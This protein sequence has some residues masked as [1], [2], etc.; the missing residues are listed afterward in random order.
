[1]NLPKNSDSAEQ[2]EVLDALP[3]L[4]F[5]E[6]AGK[7]AF[8]NAEA[9]RLLGVADGAWVPCPVEDVLWGL[10]TG[11]AEPQTQLA[12]GCEGTPFH[13]TLHCPDGQMLAVEGICHTLDPDSRD[14]VIIACPKGAA[15]T[16]RLRLMEDVLSSVPEALVIVYSRR[17]LYTNPA[18][19]RMFGYTAEEASE[20]N[21]W[22]M[23]VPENR[24]HEHALLEM[25]VDGE[26]L[27]RIETVRTNKKGQM[28]DVAILAGPL[29]VGGFK[30]GY[31]LSL[32]D[33]GERKQ[34]EARWQHDA[35]HDALTG[36]ANRALF[37]DRVTVAL[38]RRLRRRDQ[39]CGVLFVDLDRFKEINDSLGHAA[40]DAL[41]AAVSQRLRA[42]LRPQD[43]PARLGGDEFGVLV[44]NIVN[45]GDL[46]IVARRVS[47]EMQR[48]F[49]IPGH[50]IQTGASI[51]VALAGSDHTRPELL[52]RDADFA[53]YRAKEKGG[54]GYEIFDEHLEMH[55]TSQQDRERELRRVLDNRQ[56]GLLYQ[57][58]YRLESGKIEGF[59]ALLH[60][61]QVDGSVTSFDDLLA[62]AEDTGLSITLGRETLDAACRQLRQW[63]DENA[64]RELTLTVNVTQRQFYHVAMVPQLKAALAASGVEPARL[65]FEVSETTLN[66][67][68]EAAATILERV[69]ECDVR[70]ALDDFGSSLAPLNHLV[71]L[72][73]HMLKLH[74]ML[75]ADAT[76]TGRQLAVLESLIHLGRSLGM[77]VVA[78]GIETSAQLE[79]LRRIGCEM[80]QGDLL[81]GTL[82]AAQAI[83]QADMVSGGPL[84]DA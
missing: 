53:M 42:A 32:R 5:L 64:D 8:A 10:S 62:L 21:L 59:E 69:A 2:R 14:A 52:I 81:C 43:S 44:E 17:V 50:V 79:A 55:F 37:L 13:A 9:R 1:M 57:P 84:H 23:I 11:M 26:G 58:V 41:L 28:L 40:G 38:N 78:Q 67:N 49:E 63:T 82:E 70:I 66:E 54:G 20:G 27:G 45:I 68:P 4:V 35:L 7:I 77:Q 75:T 19:T 60:C 39:G 61:R 72:P 48:P 36:L 22:E 15:Q 16:P 83:R 6:Y 47:A 34:K 30:A 71:R 29:L 65:C 74:P 12:A 56:F 18:F 73:I 51:G 76:S 33:I 31:V 24:R 25:A 3:V 80:G 46:D